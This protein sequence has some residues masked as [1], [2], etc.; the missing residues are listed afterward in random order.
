MK[1]SPTLALA[2]GGIVVATGVG[3]VGKA[4]AAAETRSDVASAMSSVGCLLAVITSATLIP[5]VKAFG[6]VIPDTGF[7][8]GFVTIGS[9]LVSGCGSAPLPACISWK[10]MWAAWLAFA[11]TTA[12]ACPSPFWTGCPRAPSAATS[13]LLP[14]MSSLTESMISMCWRLTS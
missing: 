12:V 5:I 10:R 3:P 14:S 2:D 6:A 4:E 1:P 8:N 11:P 7:R 9:I 13:A